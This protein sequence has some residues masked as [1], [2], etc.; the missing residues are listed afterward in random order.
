MGGTPEMGDINNLQN[1]TLN[2]SLP[3]D[4]P[5]MNIYD[6]KKPSYSRAIFLNLIKKYYPDW[7]NGS[8][9]I[10]VKGVDVRGD[11]RHFTSLTKGSSQIWVWDSGYVEYYEA[12]ASKRWQP[13]EDGMRRAKQ[14]FHGEQGVIFEGNEL[15]SK[16]E[17]RNISIRYARD[18]GGLPADWY[19]S[20]SGGSTMMGGGS[21]ILDSYLI[22]LD[23]R[24]EGFP[25]V[26]SGGEGAMI[27]LTPLGE[28]NHYLVLW[29]EISGVRKMTTI[30][31]AAEALAYLDRHPA[32]CTMHGKMTVEAIELGYFSSHFDGV[33]TEMG[34]VW[35]FYT[36][37]KHTQ[38]EVVDAAGLS[39]SRS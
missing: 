38:Y 2:T 31:S 33:Q 18:H 39:F 22:Y 23:R 5:R 37:A 10:E 12:A 15:I 3:A 26:G 19:I 4:H 11:T 9:D 1:F 30:I 25:V 32:H 29:R 34:P 21:V 7:L 27:S 28:V 36:N 17:A 14:S 8:V 16:D 13:V 35:I 24:I 20:K 6:L